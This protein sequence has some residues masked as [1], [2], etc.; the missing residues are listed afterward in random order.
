MLI[1]RIMN[2]VSM[3]ITIYRGSIALKE[4][5]VIKL[6]NNSRVSLKIYRRG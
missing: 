2:E 5:G 3:K 4:I 6:E 1:M